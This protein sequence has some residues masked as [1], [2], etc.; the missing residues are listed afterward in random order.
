MGS[1]RTALV[2]C[3][4]TIWALQKLFGFYQLTESAFYQKHNICADWNICKKY[5]GENTV[6]LKEGRVRKYSR[7]E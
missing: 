6:Q 5:G 3:V 1:T 7:D 2:S 4:Q